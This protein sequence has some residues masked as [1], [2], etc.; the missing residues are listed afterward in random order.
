[1]IVFLLR[2]GGTFWG[3]TRRQRVGRRTFLAFFVVLFPSLVCFSFVS[4]PHRSSNFKVLGLPHYFVW[5]FDFFRQI[6]KSAF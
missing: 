1:M 3:R 2:R 4:P 6:T 5:F